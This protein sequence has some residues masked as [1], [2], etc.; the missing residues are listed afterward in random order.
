MLLGQVIGQKEYLSQFEEFTVQERSLNPSETPTPANN[1]GRSRKE[2]IK[3][4]RLSA[5][6]GVSLSVQ[7]WGQ[8]DKP[9]I[10]FIHGWS[11]SHQSW[12]EQIESELADHFH[13]VTLDNRGHGNSD[14]PLSPEYYCET[15][16]WANDVHTVIESLDLKNPLL[17]GWSY[18][19]L[20]ISDYL[21]I[22]GEETIGGVVLVSALTKAGSEEAWAVSGEGVLDTILSMF[23]TNET[24]NLEGTTKFVRMLTNEEL[25]REIEHEIIAYNMAVPTEV[26]SAMFER[27]IDNDDVLSSISVP[28][29]I[30]HG[31]MDE[32]VLCKAGELHANTVPTAD[33]LVYKSA[34]HMPFLERSERFNRDLMEFAQAAFGDTQ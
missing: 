11:Q 19:G 22:Y 1:S 23:D 8:T 5:D 15:E 25:D 18:G 13:I 9:A 12:V 27:D 3:T 32:V 16:R 20:V 31:E 29:L 17:V 34:G 10:I 2:P 7:E 4:H 30:I 6:D 21:R 28:A 24:A 26:R 14:K 33:L